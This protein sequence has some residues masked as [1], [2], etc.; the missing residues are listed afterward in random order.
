MDDLPLLLAPEP[1]ANRL[2]RKQWLEERVQELD[3]LISAEMG[4]VIRASALKFLAGLE[5][6]PETVT[7]AA[8][9]SVFD[10]LIRVW[11]EAVQN[12][13]AP[14]LQQYYLSGGITSSASAVQAGV[15]DSWVPVVN[16][17]AVAW[18]ASRVPE[19]KNIGF[20]LR[21]T[22]R[23]AVSAAIES[24]ASTQRVQQLILSK[25][26]MPAWR[27]HAIARTEVN[28][29]YSYGNYESMAA[30]PTE[31]QPVEKYWLTSI[32]SRERDSHREM[33]LVVVR[34]SDSFI[35]GES[36]SPMAHP[37]DFSAPAE[38]VVN[39]RCEMLELYE[40]DDRPGGRGRAGIDPLV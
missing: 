13:I 16:Q 21:D 17:N 39:C 3:D 18:S 33:N 1:P 9:F 19:L 34:F 30:L 31:F 10:E 5:D 6:T 23:Q 32:D 25:A 8:D 4:K 26:D 15:V 11:E 28:A 12:R 14:N 36:R 27:A 20:A 29:A 38:E 22:V 37:H 35:V 7:A 2:E 40:G 24:G